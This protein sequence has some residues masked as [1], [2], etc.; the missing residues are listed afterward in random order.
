MLQEVHAPIAVGTAGRTRSRLDY[1]VVTTAI[2]LLVLGIVAVAISAYMG[3]TG[4]PL[5]PA[6]F[7]ME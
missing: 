7:P 2:V 5:D 6:S 4:Y 1:S 3:A